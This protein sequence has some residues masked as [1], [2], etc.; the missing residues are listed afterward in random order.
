MW[1]VIG[2]NRAVSLLKR[3][4]EIDAVSHAYLFTGPAHVGKMTLAINLAQAVNCQVA[5]PPCG[6]CGSCQKIASV[7]HADVQILDLNQDED[8]AEAEKRVKIGVGQIEQLQHSASLPPFEGKYKVFIINGA[9]LL[10]IAAANR[11]LKTLEEPVG[12]VIFILLTTSEQLLPVTIISRCQRVELLP[13]ATAALEE[14]LKSRWGIEAEKAKLLATLARGCPGWALSAIQDDRLLQ[15]R[16]QYL[17]ELLDIIDT[18]IEERFSYVARLATQFYQNRGL[19]QEKL[20][21]WLDWWRDLLLVTAGSSD[22]VYNV[23]RLDTLE[24]MAKGYNLRQIRKYVDC[25][26]AASRQLGQNVN[27]QLVLEV[28][29]LEIPETGKQGR[30][31]AAARIEVEHG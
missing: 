6:Q 30:V 29:M 11:L 23:D 15:Q 1:Q 13:L 31:R 19:V 2:Q 12:K 8:S 4:L 3:S 16:D 25:I 10:S 28:L 21:L 27:P 20:N 9:D 18:G 5:E 17:D 24:K 26:Q 7:K 14:M 22:I